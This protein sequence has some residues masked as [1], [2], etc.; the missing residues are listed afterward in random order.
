MSDKPTHKI[1]Q[2]P[3]KHPHM[4]ADNPNAL[5]WIAEDGLLRVGDEEVAFRLSPS[6]AREWAKSLWAY[7]EA[8]D[9]TNN[10]HYE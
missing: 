3:K 9:N 10:D 5:M 8:H 1:P 6:Q 4:D 2:D 7:S